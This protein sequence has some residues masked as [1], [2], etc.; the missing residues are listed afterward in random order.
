MTL[1]NFILRASS[2]VSLVFWSVVGF[3]AGIG[4]FVYGFRLLQRRRLILD[5]PF[6]KIRSAS[7]GMVEIS[8]LADGPYTMIAPITGRS[9]Y[10]HRTLIWEW[11]R[12]GKDSEWVKVASE[13]MHVPFFVDDNT[14]RML[15]DPRGADLDLHCDFEQEFC[16]SFFTTKE[17]APENVRNFLARHGVMTGNKIK[18]Q[19]F[20]IKPKNALFILGTAS[21]NPGIELT[22][23][24]IP[25]PDGV[26]V[27]K[28]S[29]G[30]SISVSINASSSLLNLPLETVFQQAASAVGQGPA[31]TVALSSG[32][33]AA[34]ALEMTQQERIAAA[35]R[36]AG[37]RDPAI[38]D[39]VYSSNGNSEPAVKAAGFDPDPP[40]V[41]MKG[42]NNKTF[43]ISWRSQR[44]VVRALGW[45]STLMIWG[46]PVLAILS[47]YLF[48][49][50]ERL[51]TAN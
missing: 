7:L 22:S 39:R 31:R 13:C 51:F 42:A 17:P 38:S 3:F 2:P 15:V 21:E 19:E 33:A 46:G 12:R 5:T 45:K 14:G 49:S 10:Y 30:L 9:C 27:L 24:P 32:M 36:K 50:A 1:A 26:S 37:I 8:G 40:V 6:S 35:I 4:L 28:S 44:E 48:L 18:V 47:L 16:S 20:C 25:D 23:E 11:K 29:S 34:T 43:L 41:L